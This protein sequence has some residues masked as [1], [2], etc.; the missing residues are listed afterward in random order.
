[1]RP[2]GDEGVESATGGVRTM[3]TP[4]WWSSASAIEKSITKAK[5]ECLCENKKYEYIGHNIFL[6]ARVLYRCNKT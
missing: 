3:Q 4:I 2:Y 1:M 5:E 6:N